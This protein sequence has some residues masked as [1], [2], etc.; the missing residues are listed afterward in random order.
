[1]SKPRTKLTYKQELFLKKYVENGGNGTK[2]ALAV[3]NTDRPNVANAIAVENLQKPAISDRLKAMKE[4]IAESMIRVLRENNAME[5]CAES[6]LRDLQSD[7]PKVVE[8]GRRY[9]AD[10]Y[11]IVHPVPQ[12]VTDNR[13]QILNIP[14]R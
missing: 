12:S 14:A 2:A 3:Y 11:K 4:E 13:K 1:M 10:F 9:L 7:D 8:L 6:A 5:R